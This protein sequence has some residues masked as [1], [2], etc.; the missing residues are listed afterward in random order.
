[1]ARHVDTRLVLPPNDRF[2]GFTDGLV[3]GVLVDLPARLAPF[4]E[5]E[6]PVGS[7]EASHVRREDPFLASFHPMTPRRTVCHAYFII[8]SYLIF[9]IDYQG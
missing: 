2:G 1:V 8:T 9:R 5:L 4:E 7:R 6:H 3:E